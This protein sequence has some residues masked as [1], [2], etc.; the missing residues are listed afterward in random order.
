MATFEA[1]PFS[2]SHLPESAERTRYDNFED[3]KHAIYR[4]PARMHGAWAN[5][6]SL[7][8]RPWLHTGVALFLVA[9]EAESWQPLDRDRVCLFVLSTLSRAASTAQ[10]L[11]TRILLIGDQGSGP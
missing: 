10:E 7:F 11:L 8:G 4:G 9:F 3:Y 6:T 5:R 1:A 2:V